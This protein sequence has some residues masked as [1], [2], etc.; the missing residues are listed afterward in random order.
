MEGEEGSTFPSASLVLCQ[1]HFDTAPLPL[2]SDADVGSCSAIYAVLGSFRGEGT[3]EG[4]AIL[5][6]HVL[7]LE[8]WLGR[9]VKKMRV[10]G[11][12]FS[13]KT[14]RMHSAFNELC[15]TS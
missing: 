7:H 10:E 8:I 13:R 1:P 14:G 11:N 2:C 6:L 4:Q 9:V 15:K 12:G 5:V 3:K